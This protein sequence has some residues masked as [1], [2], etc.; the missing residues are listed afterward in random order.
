M[1]NRNG[2]S[3][4]G[5]APANPN[6][7][8]DP[9]FPASY[10][11][12]LHVGIIRKTDYTLKLALHWMFNFAQDDRIQYDVNGNPLRDNMVT[13]GIDESHA[14]DGRINVFG[15]DA[16]MSHPI[17]GLLAIGGSHIDAHARVAAAR[18]ADVRRR[19]PRPDGALAGRRHRRHGPGRRRRPS[20]T[21]AAWAASSAATSRSTPTARTCCSTRAPCSR[22]AHAEPVRRRAR[23]LRQPPPLQVRRRR[24]VRLPALHGGGPAHRSRGAELEG[25]RRERSTSSP[26]AWSSRPTGRA[27]RASC[28]STPSGSTGPTPTLK[29]SSVV[30]PRLDDQLVAVNVNIWW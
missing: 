24:P 18:P 7:N 28:C 14:T 17:Y 9:S 3:P 13:R 30:V 10:V 29:N 12:H 21:A 25:L 5:V 22:L 1:G 19:G 11:Q 20:T 8:V 16:S 15:I 26:R 6:N 2:R 23:L 4:A 27:A